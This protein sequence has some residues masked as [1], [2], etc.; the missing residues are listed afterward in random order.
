MHESDIEFPESE[1]SEDG[2][3]L[4]NEERGCGHLDTGKGYL[5]SDVT[6]AGGDLPAMVEIPDAMRLPFKEE[7]FRTWKQFPGIQ[8]ELALNENAADLDEKESSAMEYVAALSNGGYHDGELWSHLKRLAGSAHPLDTGE[9]GSDHYGTMR[10]AQAHDL[11]MW[12][13]ETYYPQPEDFIEETKARGLNKAISMSTRNPP[14]VVN[15]G[16]TRLFLIHPKGIDNHPEEDEETLDEM[17]IEEDDRYT[18]AIIGYAYIT[19]CI[20]TEDEDGRIPDYIQRWETANDL[21]VVSVGREISFEEME[22][23]SL[24]DAAEKAGEEPAEAE[25]DD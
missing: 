3:V 9:G 25:S 24:D 8:F 2:E 4:N 12:V 17:G 6:G 21:D 1:F 15:P 22:N 5:R 7:H 10:V 18:P 13:G 14:P 11:I 23:E 19:R 20:Y 16:K